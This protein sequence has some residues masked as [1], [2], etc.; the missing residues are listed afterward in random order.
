MHRS[1][2]RPQY[3]QHPGLFPSTKSSN[4]SFSSASASVPIAASLPPMS[5]Q[6]KLPPSA[7]TFISAPPQTPP[8]ASPLQAPPQSVPSSQSGN[9]YIPVQHH[10]F[11]SKYV[12]QRF[13]WLPMSVIDSL[14]LEDAYLEG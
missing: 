4:D 14:K 2:S 10:W 7:G 8:Q 9:F 13:I 11:Y 6:Q 12:E 1:S 3:A 5:H